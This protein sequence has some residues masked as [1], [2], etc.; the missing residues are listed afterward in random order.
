M[1][2]SPRD[3]ATQAQRS[4][5]RRARLLQRIVDAEQATLPQSDEVMALVADLLGAHADTGIEMQTW[6][7][8]LAVVE[9]HLA[10]SPRA[11]AELREIGVS[12]WFTIV[13]TWRD[14]HP[15]SVAVT[16]GRRNLDLALGCWQRQ[17]RALTT[18]DAV[19]AA[20]DDLMATAPHT[21]TP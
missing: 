21:S 5:L 14:G 17:Q 3:V 13:G 6:P 16:P 4:M 9:S 7:R 19:C 18:A 11:S 12:T 20:V 15:L 8:A 1:S 10:A 2:D